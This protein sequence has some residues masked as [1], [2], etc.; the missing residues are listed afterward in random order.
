MLPL[1]AL[2]IAV[3]GQ[4]V[5]SPC[6]P[7]SETSICAPYQSLSIN[8][9]KLAPVYG[10]DPGKFTP[11]IWEAKLKQATSGRNLKKYWNRWIQCTGY[12]GEPFQYATSYDCLT[13]L[14][15]YSAE[16]N[17]QQPVPPLCP[18]VC[19]QYG[20]AVVAMVQQPSMCPDL[21][22]ATVMKRRSALLQASERCQAILQNP[23]FQGE[24]IPGVQ[25]D[26]STCGTCLFI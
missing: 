15:V 22:D 1:V 23:M 10:V 4:Q 12:Q 24:C 16:C 13:D 19:G 11:Q 26:S 9:Q 2:I 6:V 3:L 7:I 21:E 17:Q 8:I 25:S 18:D 14:F 20:A 5:P